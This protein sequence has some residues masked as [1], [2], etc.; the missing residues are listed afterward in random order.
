MRLTRWRTSRTFRWSRARRVAEWNERQT[1]RLDRH[2]APVGREGELAEA[3]KIPEDQ[4]RVIVPDTGSAYGG[5][6]TGEAAIEAARLA[7]AADK[8]VKLIWTREEEF[9]WAYFRP[10]GVIDI[11]SGVSKDGLITAWEFHNYNSGPSA[12][13]SPYEIAN[14]TAQFHPTDSPLRQGS[15]RGLAATANHFA[16]ESHMDD[17]AAAVG[18]DPLEFRLKNLKNDRLRAVLQAAAEKFGW[19]KTK[20]DSESWVRPGLRRGKGRL[21][22]HLRRDFHRAERISGRGSDACASR[23]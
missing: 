6:H 7:K 17:L 20:T 5:K 4:V 10:A 16:R 23:R 1:H 13:E 8:P 19:G 3:F 14:H 11:R 21:R 22:G 15:Y 12:I 9:T 2:A 18:M